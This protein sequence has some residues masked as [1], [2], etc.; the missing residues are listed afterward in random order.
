MPRTAHRPRPDRRRRDPIGVIEPPLA[1]LVSV[2][3]DGID[4]TQAMCEFTCPVTK[5]GTAGISD[6]T[7]GVQFTGVLSGIGSRFLQCSFDGALILDDHIEGACTAEFGWEYGP[8]VTA[9][10]SYIYARE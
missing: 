9:A 2:V 5:A 6:A 3:I 4:T 10:L 8:N 1:A 7:S